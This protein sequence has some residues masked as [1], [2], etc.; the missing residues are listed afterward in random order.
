MR[1]QDNPPFDNPRHRL[2][3][4]SASCRTASGEIPGV[5]GLDVDGIDVDGIDR[6]P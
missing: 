6:Q 5:G 3:D 2:Y 1:C 4:F